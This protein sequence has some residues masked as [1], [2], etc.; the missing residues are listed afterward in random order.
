MYYVTRYVKQIMCHE[1][2][3]RTHVSPGKSHLSIWKDPKSDDFVVSTNPVAL[4]SI[5]PDH[6]Q[7]YEKQKKVNKVF[8]GEGVISGLNIDSQGLLKCCLT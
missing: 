2:L 4:T 6:T 3:Y 8:E 7:E 1:I 5:G